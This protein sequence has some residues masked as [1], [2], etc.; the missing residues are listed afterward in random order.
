MGWPVE[1]FLMSCRK[2]PLRKFRFD[3]PTLLVVFFFTSHF[4]LQTYPIFLRKKF[5]I[6]KCKIGP[7][8]KLDSANSKF[9]FDVILTRRRH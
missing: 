3:P 2:I 9:I 8:P 1:K 4:W 6:T 7:P 5:K